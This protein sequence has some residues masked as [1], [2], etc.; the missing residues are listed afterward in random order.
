LTDCQQA[1][2]LTLETGDLNSQAHTWDSLGY[3]NRHLGRHEEALDCYR[4]ALALFRATG[5]RHS[6]ATGLAYLG[7]THATAADHEAAHAAWTE[8]LTITEELGLPA[9]DP[10]RARIVQSLSTEHENR[11]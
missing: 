9:T 8:A 3:I 2:A 1:L 11:R 10:L 6:E 7:D 5:D 4:Q